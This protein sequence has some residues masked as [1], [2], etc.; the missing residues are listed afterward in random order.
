MM[1]SAGAAPSRPERASAAVHLTVTSRLYQPAR[2]GSVVAA[3]L[4]VGAVLSTLIG[5]TVASLLL[6]A[7]SVAVPLTDCAFPSP[8]VEGAGQLAM[9]ERLSPQR[10]PTGTS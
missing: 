1:L 2:F 9:P 7:V 10:K 3:P 8:R 5:P 6:P 4:S